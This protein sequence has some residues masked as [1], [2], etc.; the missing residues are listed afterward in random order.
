[1][2]PIPYLFFAGNCAEAL[3]TYAEI[4]GTD[5]PEMLPISSAP[6]AA[7]FPPEAQHKI[8]HGALKVGDGWIYA[9]DNVGGETS[10]MAG[11]SIM[12]GF[13]TLEE[14]RRVFDALTK[15]GT[16]TMPFEKT[17]WSNGFG[18]VTDRFGTRWMISVAETPQP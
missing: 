13:P 3:T 4:L 5:D 8:M 2:T 11:C 7:E 17:F 18:T 16:V 12:L 6:M 14:A 15:G 10:A 9:S 1:M